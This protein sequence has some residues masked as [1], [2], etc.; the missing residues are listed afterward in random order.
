MHLFFPGVFHTYLCVINVDFDRWRKKCPCKREGYMPQ[1]VK[2][3]HGGSLLYYLLPVP[4]GP[5]TFLQ[6]KMYVL[7]MVDPDAPSRTKPTSAHWR[8]WLVVDM[9]GSALK[10][11]HIKG[12]TL[13]EYAPPTPPQETGFHRYQFMLFEQLPDAPVSLTEREKSSR[14]K[15]DL[16]AF[17]RRFHLGEPVATLQFLTQNYKD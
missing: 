17:I 5:A 16:E 2:C 8:H 4:A 6:K 15:W 11:G 10:N 14:G 7:V 13:T 12:T 9:Q 1:C 3:N